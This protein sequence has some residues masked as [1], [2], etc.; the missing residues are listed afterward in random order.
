MPSQRAGVPVFLRNSI[1]DIHFRYDNANAKHTR[2]TVFLN[3]QNCGQL[4]VGTDQAEQLSVITRDGCE[5]LPEGH[6]EF[7]RSGHRH[8]PT[9]DNLTTA[10]KHEKLELLQ[11]KNK[12]TRERLAQI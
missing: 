2:I 12:K 3:G 5:F 6:N 10:E 9:W 11:E 1:V 7:K 8:D 4:V